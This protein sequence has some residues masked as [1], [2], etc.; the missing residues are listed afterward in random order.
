MAP[1]SYGSVTWVFGV[2]NFGLELTRNPAQ[3][4]T[5]RHPAGILN[6]PLETEVPVIIVITGMTVAVPARSGTQ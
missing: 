6:V 4:P 3:L 1:A 2:M 5:L